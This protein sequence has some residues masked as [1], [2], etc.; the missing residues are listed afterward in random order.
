MNIE[1]LRSYC[2]SKKGVTES[3]PFDEDTL[4]FKVM[5]KMFCLTSISEPDSIN[6][7]CEPEKAI[8]LR[9]QY[10]CVQPGYH[11]NKKM[12]NTV[13]IDGSISKKLL[14]DWIDHSYNEVVAGLPKKLQIELGIK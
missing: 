2:L 8:E 11:M 13:E 5:G 7:K 9:E 6:L 4:V 1:E 12:W 10:P 3:F 14:K